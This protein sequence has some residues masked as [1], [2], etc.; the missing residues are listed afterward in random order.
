MDEAEK[1][2]AKYRLSKAETELSISK[3]LFENKFYAKS[4]NS[5][6]YTMFYAVRALLALDKLDSKKHSG[7]LNYFNNLYIKTEKFSKEYFKYL[8]SAF[9]IRLQSDYNDFFVATKKD[10]ENQIE[11]AQKFLVAVK[12]FLANQKGIK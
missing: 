8:N 5:S 7:V 4:L 10:A 12:D 2:L 6:Y 3:V 11:N 1:S 9:T